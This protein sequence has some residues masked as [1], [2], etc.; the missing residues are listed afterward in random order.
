MSKILERDQISSEFKWDI[1]SMYPDFDRWEADFDQVSVLIDQIKAQSGQ[2]CSS[3]V[4]LL[5]SIE[6]SLKS[7]RLVSNLFTFA[8]MSQD[9]NTKDN[10]MQE[11]SARAEQIATKLSEASS[12]IV[13]EILSAD[14]DLIKG[15]ISDYEP[16]N[17]YAQYLDDIIRRKPHTLSSS[18]EKILAMSGD[19]SGLAGTTF[20]MMNSA[21]LKFPVVRDSKG[22][23]IQLSHGNFV[24][25]L[26]SSDRELRKDA[27]KAYYSVY[28]QFNNSFASLL[29]GEVK[30]N[31]FYSKV[32]NH[33]TARS[34]ALFEN[35]VPE[36][37]YDQLIDAVN[38]NLS[39][40]HK[41]MKI[42]KKALGVKELHMYDLYTPIIKDVD[43]K[44][45]YGEA[46]DMVL[47]SLKPLGD[48]YVSVVETSFSDG[49]I[50][51]YE[52]I[53][54][55]SG[56]YSFGTYD[57][58]P[59]ILLNY[60]DTL[61]NAFTLTHEMGHSMHSYLTRKN[62]EYVYGNYSIFLAEVA[63]TTNEALLNHF[64]LENVKSKQ[65]EL[66]ILNH[67]LE[68]FRGT[69]Y[70]QAMF[71]EFERDIHAMVERGEA[72]TGDK[73]NNHYMSLNVKYYG[74]YMIVDE[75]IKYEW[76]RIPHFYYNFY[77]F[78]YA[79]GFSAAVALS[80]SIL[81]NGADGL[82]KYL[83]FLE[84]GSSEYP[85][86]ILKKAGAD[87]TTTAPVSN[88]LKLFGELVNKMERLLD[89]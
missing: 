66:F 28:E 10:S 11:Y 68:Q 13:P 33:K 57:S 48:K 67:Y 34:A 9:Q 45:K 36:T 21:D 62:Q 41:Y 73:L 15:F 80:Q 85:I 70:R 42:R 53:G 4:N 40:M 14:I 88:A 50:D 35:N 22:N 20:G 12:Y 30:K 87:M 5:S 47:N 19:I 7:S 32:K 27:F 59:F 29:Y 26:E 78:Q 81:E 76:S 55:R 52:N 6:L 46:K 17:K 89:M 16:L 31:V 25:T 75:D 84:S 83:G 65:E 77:V 18:E 72:L 86:E 74:E 82:G 56:A 3:A 8:K 58:K 49:W 2:V 24:P 61:D 38:D 54:K 63:S 44:I 60:H 43:M 79:T 64:L 71:A 1:K 23:E 51:V 69:V 39:H 37:V